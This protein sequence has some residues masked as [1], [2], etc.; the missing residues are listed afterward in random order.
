M[1]LEIRQSDPIWE[2]LSCQGEVP[3]CRSGHSLTIIGRRAYLFGGCGP[4]KDGSAT[5]FE[6]LYCLDLTTLTWNLVLT[7]GPCPRG[8]RRH[9]A[10]STSTNQM[11]VFGGE[12]KQEHSYETR[13]LNDCWLLEIDSNQVSWKAIHPSDN[14]KD[15]DVAVPEP[16]CHHSSVVFNE[17]MWVFG[18]YGGPTIHT[19]SCLGDL[20]SLD[21]VSYIFRRPAT[22]GRTPTARAGHSASLVEGCL[23]LIAGGRDHASPLDDLHILNLETLCWSWPAGHPS[24]APPMT[25]PAFGHLAAAVDSAPAAKLFVFGGQTSR[26]GDRR[27]WTHAEQLR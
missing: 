22:Q 24:P 25:A 8:R 18:G 1:S 3:S 12:G 17:G 21:L 4:A 5:I 11:I 26:D 2:R 20:W 7:S 6:Q 19:R 23:M 10:N 13:R 14:H 9:S 27:S 16:R 15:V